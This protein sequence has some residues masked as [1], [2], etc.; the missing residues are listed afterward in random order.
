MLVALQ[1]SLELIAVCAPIVERVRIADSD[2]AD[3][4][5]RALNSTRL[6]LAEASGRQGR[7][8]KARYRAAA[9]EAQEAKAALQAV[10][11]WGYVPASELAVAERLA[12]RLGGLTYGLAR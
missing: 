2:L 12:H 7:D 9:G 10:A 3:Q 8:Q 6:Q 5:R 11:A 1:V 4:L